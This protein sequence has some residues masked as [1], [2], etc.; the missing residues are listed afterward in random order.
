MPS[1]EPRDL[2]T[3]LR[4]R[5]PWGKIRR[6]V[7]NPLPAIAFH[8]AWRRGRGLWSQAGQTALR[9]L[10]LPPYTSP[11]RDE[12]LSLHAQRLRKRIQELDRQVEEP[13]RQR[14]QALRLR[15]HP[16]VGAVTVLAT[17]VFL[18]DARRFENGKA[19]ARL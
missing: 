3:L 4:D 6:R 12:R 17:E 18:G 14:S 7:Q 1:T 16:G 8:H 11:R 9:V 13:A 10:P 19:V 2:P 15:T 5:H